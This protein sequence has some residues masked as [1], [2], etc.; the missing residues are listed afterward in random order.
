MLYQILTRESFPF[1]NY[2]DPPLV[3]GAHICCRHRHRR[4]SAVQVDVAILSGD[5]GWWR[6]FNRREERRSTQLASEYNSYVISY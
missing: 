1:S 3:R 6:S 5:S 4:W 2:L